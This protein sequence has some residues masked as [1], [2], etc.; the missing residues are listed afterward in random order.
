MSLL[1][2]VESLFEALVEGSF[3]KAFAAPLQPIEIA[4]ALEREML[5]K[6]AVGSSSVDVP[7]Y[8]VAH[9]NPADFER[10]LA[11]R[12]TVERDAAA[13]LERRASELDLRPIG[14]VRVQLASEPRV[15]RGTVRPVA[16]FD[17][18]ATTMESTVDQT[19]RLEPLRLAR[20]K[21]LVL[22]DEEGGTTP[23]DVDPLRIGRGADNDLVIPDVRVS[24]YHVV[25]EPAQDGW[26]VR[27]LQST[28]G[29]FLDGE[30]VKEARMDGAA[31]L[32]LGGYQMVLRAG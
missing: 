4:R 18:E 2:R 23:L 13:H 19:R 8:Y 3:R 7:N 24:R 29:T 17:E 10:L 16:S 11:L 5:A 15:S 32:S 14:M 22:V 25:I 12:A 6:R 28:N 1:A 31:E 9:V 26:I 30:R 27:D 20:G 21:R